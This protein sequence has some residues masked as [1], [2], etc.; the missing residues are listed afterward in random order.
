MN[1]ESRG[2]QLFLR[3]GWFMASNQEMIVQEMSTVIT[4]LL[5][6]RSTTIEMGI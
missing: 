2:Q 1:K 4:D 5:I 3:L 6:G